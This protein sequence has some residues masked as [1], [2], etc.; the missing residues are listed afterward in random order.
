MTPSTSEGSQASSIAGSGINARDP[1]RIIPIRVKHVD[2]NDQIPFAVPI[3]M[4]ADGIP[5]LRNAVPH[6]LLPYRYAERSR[7]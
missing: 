2:L 1:Q 7:I 4:D 3:S 5:H 6:H